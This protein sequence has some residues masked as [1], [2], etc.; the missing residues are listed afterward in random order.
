MRVHDVVFRIPNPSCLALDSQ[1]RA[2]SLPVTRLETVRQLS[3]PVPRSQPSRTH[4]RETQK[5]RPGLNLHRII[6][7]SGSLIIYKASARPSRRR[8]EQ[9]DADPPFLASTNPP[10]PAPRSTRSDSW[11]WRSKR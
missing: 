7:A 3:A 8:R 2:P 4:A 5:P 10:W 6:P 1:H 11:W 9:T